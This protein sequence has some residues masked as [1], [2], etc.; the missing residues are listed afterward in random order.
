MFAI[1][2]LTEP[3]TDGVVSLRPAAE[4]D[5]PEILIAH[6]DD[7]E[8]FIR[9]GEERPPS[10]AELGRRSERAEAEREAGTRVGLTIVEPGSDVCVGQVSTHRIDPIN[11]RAALGVWLAPQARGRGFAPRALS[12]TAR[13]LF[14]SCHLERL[15]IV[16]EPDNRAMIA[17]ARTAGFEFEGVLRGYA[18]ER[19][20]RVDLAIMS[21]LPA[22]LRR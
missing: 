2:A 1:P 11:A 7:P 9:L 18:R 12:L 22:D 19:G 3:I 15:E 8:L 21:L 16:T 4:R 14:E 13:W 17:S 20:Q 6:Q 10:G 5:I